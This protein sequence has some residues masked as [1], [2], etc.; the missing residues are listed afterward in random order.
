M[1]GALT[2]AVLQHAKGKATTVT[3]NSYRQNVTVTICSSL[4]TRFDLQIRAVFIYIT[5]KKRLGFCV[6]VALF[7]YE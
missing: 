1:P 6:G 2:V 7:L 3:S 4:N 5:L